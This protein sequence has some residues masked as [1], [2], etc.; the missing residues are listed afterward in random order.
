MAYLPACLLAYPTRPSSPTLD[1]PVNSRSTSAVHALSSPGRRSG[2]TKPVRMCVPLLSRTFSV[3]GPHAVPD[4]LTLCTRV[5]DFRRY[6]YRYW[7][8]FP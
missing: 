1:V 3:T 6:L 7:V 4:L 8:P 5:R 2:V